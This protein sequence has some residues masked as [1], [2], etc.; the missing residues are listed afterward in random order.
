MARGIDPEKLI[1]LLFR[2]G[3]R[4]GGACA[5]HFRRLA[6]LRVDQ[7]TAC[8]RSARDACTCVKRTIRARWDRGKHRRCMFEPTIIQTNQKIV[9]TPIRSVTV[10]AAT[11]NSISALSTR[12]SI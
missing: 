12:M 4:A 1:Y 10:V 6:D 3:W 2:L 11:A 5:G 7:I 8:V 9:V